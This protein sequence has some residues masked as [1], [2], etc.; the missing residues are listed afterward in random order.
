MPFAAGS[1]DAIYCISLFTHLDETMQD[2]WLHEIARR[3]K[4][5]GLPEFYQTSFH[6]RRYV[7]EHW[8]KILEVVSY[9][10]GGIQH[11]Q[12]IVVLRR[13]QARE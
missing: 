10:P 6:S 3:I 1:F 12:D 7:M 2:I 11:H 8:S 13:P 9:V 5:D 4:L